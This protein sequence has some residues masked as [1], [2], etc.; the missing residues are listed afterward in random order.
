MKKGLLIVSLLCFCLVAVAQ[1]DAAGGRQRSRNN[2]NEN[3]TI[4][5]HPYD[6]EQNTVVAPE[7]SH[8][9]LVGHVGFNATDGDFTSEA[10]HPIGY[11]S[12]GLDVEYS[13]TPVWTFGVEYMFSWYNVTGKSGNAGTLLNGY[14]HKAGAYLSMD[15]AN[16]IFPKLE[17]KIFSIQP[18]IGGGASWY[19]STKYYTDDAYYDAQK[20][21]WINPTHQRGNTLNYIN[22]DGKNGPDYDTKYSFMPYLQAGLN[23]EFNLNRSIGLGVR[24]AYSY[25]TRDYLDGRGATKGMSA[26]ASKNNDGLVDVTLNLRWKIQPRKYTHERNIAHTGQHQPAE[27]ALKALEDAMMNGT[28][29]AGLAGHDTVIIHHDTVIIRETNTYEHI[30]KAKDLEQYYYVYFENNKSNLDNRAL[31]TIQQVADRL[32]EDPDLYAVIVGYCDNTGSNKLNYALGD[33]RAD[34]VADE[35]LEEYGIDATHLYAGGVGKIVGH[36]SKGSYAPNRRAAI[37]LVDK[38]TFDRMRGEVE[39]KRSNRGEDTPTNDFY[40]QE[41]EPNADYTPVK[42]IP[43]SESARPVKKNEFKERESETVTSGKATTLAKLA[44]EYYNN[45][46]C[47]VYIYIAN[48][49]KLKNP[50][51]LKPGTDLI[52][53]ELTESEMKITKDEGLVIYNNARQHR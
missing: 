42:T 9:S 7:F 12:A 46:Y 22:K 26:H 35:L 47:W 10:K 36:R 14:M 31:V 32:Q 6:L 40:E 39:G 19:K 21:K 11:P 50:N 38:D 44:R 3:D 52:I 1:D 23:V 41:E 30:E 24:A 49:D 29:L 2:S 18:F 48:M 53:P 13:F 43:L 16:L 33:R 5:A 25:F 8:W 51:N 15:L 34:V 28:A 4:G 20:A 37:R 45:T 27:K 17:K